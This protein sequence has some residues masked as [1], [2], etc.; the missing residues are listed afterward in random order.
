MQ[1]IVKGGMKAKVFEL[2]MNNEGS[3]KE[4]DIIDELWFN[5]DSTGVPAKDWKK[6]KNNL[7]SQITYLRKAL[8]EHNG[9]I[10]KEEGSIKV[11]FVEPVVVEPEVVLEAGELQ[12][13]RCGVIFES[14]EQVDDPHCL[15]CVNILMA[16]LGVSLV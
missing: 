12:C 15:D 14:H 13:V 11:N 10:V 6:A 7:A 8:K 4:S 5:G 16:E 9:T 3:M 1:S 2:I